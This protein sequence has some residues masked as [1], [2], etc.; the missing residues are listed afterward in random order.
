MSPGNVVVVS[1]IRSVVPRT[2]IVPMAYFKVLGMQ[3]EKK[4][5]IQ[6]TRVP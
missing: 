5:D 3:A 1:A 2:I 4:G 6:I